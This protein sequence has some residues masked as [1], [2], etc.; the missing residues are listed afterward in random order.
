MGASTE[1][2]YELFEEY[3]M[4]V[5]FELTLLSRLR[6]IDKKFLQRASSQVDTVLYFHERRQPHRPLIQNAEVKS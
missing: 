1:E 4:S 5:A 3:G 6:P 2:L